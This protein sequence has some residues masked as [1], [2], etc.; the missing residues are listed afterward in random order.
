MLPLGKKTPSDTAR[1][2]RYASMAALIPAIL[3]LSPLVGWFLGKWVGGWIHYPRQ[4]ALVGVLLGFIAGVR[5]T[6]NLIRRINE[7][8]R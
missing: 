4:G 3:V 5:E 1:M 6:I 8:L 2:L 7:E